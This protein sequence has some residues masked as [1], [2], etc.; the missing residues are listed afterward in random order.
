M[1][2][3]LAFLLALILTGSVFAKEIKTSF[4]NDRIF[5]KLR[6]NGVEAIML[7]DSGGNT[8]LFPEYVFYWK[9]EGSKVEKNYLKFLNKGPFDNFPKDVLTD[10]SI[11]LMS[12]QDEELVMIRKVVKDGLFGHAWFG[13][14]LWQLSYSEK[15]LKLLN[16]I[17]SPRGQKV[18]LFFKG[19]GYFYPRMSI[20]VED[21]SLDVLFDTGGTSVLSEVA[22]NELNLKDAIVASSFIR[23]SIF[24]KWQKKHPDWKVIQAGDRFGNNDLIRVPLVVVA[25]KKIGPIWFA[26]RPN[27]AYDE[28]MS[29]YMDCKCAGAI[30]GNVLKY[31]D[32]TLDYPN[33]AAWFYRNSF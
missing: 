18:P 7:L 8:G 2:A 6:F 13:N 25:G 15:S 22:M 23:E 32:I 12:G 24:N 33:K 31:F 21:E 30:G 14:R 10:N 1:K 11:R 27:S 17:D 5:A 4:E 9:T 20:S 26:K 29:Q 19:I 28:M 3:T 16:K